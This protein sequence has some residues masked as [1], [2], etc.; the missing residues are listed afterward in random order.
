VALQWLWT[1]AKTEW[2]AR[3]SPGPAE[4]RSNGRRRG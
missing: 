4:R 2:D 3:P 1:K